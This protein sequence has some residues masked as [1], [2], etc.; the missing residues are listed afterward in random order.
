[1]KRLRV[2]LALLALVVLL[3]AGLGAALLDVLRPDAADPTIIRAPRAERRVRTTGDADAACVLDVEVRAAG[4][5]DEPGAPVPEAVVRL[6]WGEWGQPTDSIGVDAE[7]RVR[8]AAACG[9]ARVFVEAPGFAPTTARFEPSPGVPMPARIV[10]FPGVRV[11][12]TVVSTAA[13]PVPGAAVSVG[14]ADTTTAADGTWSVWAGAEKGY[15]GVRAFGFDGDYVVYDGRGDHPDG[16]R[17]D[18]TLTPRHELRV[19]CAG[20]PDDACTGMPMQCTHPL[21]PVG[22][23]CHATDVPGETVCTCPEGEVAVRGGGRAVLVDA[24]AQEAWLDFRDTGRIVGRVLVDGQPAAQCTVDGAR[25]PAALEDLPRGL[26]VTRSTFCDADGRFVLEGLVLGDWQVVAQNRRWDSEDT[27]ADGGP[28]LERSLVPRRVRLREEVDVGDILLP[29]GGGLEGVVVDGLTGAPA[30]EEPIAAWREGVGGER[31]TIAL[32][33]SGYD[34]GSFRIQGLPPGRW[35]VAHV[36][37][38][39]DGVVVTVTEGVVTRG[40]RIT[41][42]D[43]T[44]LDEN[45]FALTT[46]GGALV[47]QDVTPGSPAADAGLEPG[48]EVVGVLL[49]GFDLSSAMGE[50][51]AE[52]ARAVLGHWDGP[53]VTLVVR[54]ADGGEEEVPLEW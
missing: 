19:W 33:E 20:L 27:P 14:G 16:L 30:S 24:D 40:I 31:I 50:D 6:G 43:A 11:Y 5:G 10:L 13:E 45:G 21:S 12:G 8:A 34:D 54:G 42:S 38:P 17:V 28:F 49:G 39:H 22:D 2:P 51:G 41:T 9:V 36:L 37:A 7:G 47:V 35:T 4:E 3:C 44:A 48:E 18:F 52:F 15:V 32:D 46:E 29:G 53:G 1:M 26:F 25:I 23:R